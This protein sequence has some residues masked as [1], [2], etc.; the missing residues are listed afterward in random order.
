MINGA[1][2]YVQKPVNMPEFRIKVLRALRQSELIRDSSSRDVIRNNLNAVLREADDLRSRLKLV[3]ELAQ[4]LL[5]ESS[6]G[7]ERTL[8]VASRIVEKTR[9]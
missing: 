2:D 8:E 6:P 4:S 5:D 1:F 3:H 7:L 9:G